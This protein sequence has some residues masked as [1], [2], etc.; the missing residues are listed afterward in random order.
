MKDYGKM[1]LSQ[2]K[3]DLKSRGAKIS[4]RKRE[5]VERLEAYDRNSNFNT[6][7]EEVNKE[8]EMILPSSSNYKDVNKDTEFPVITYNDVRFYL[9]PLGKQLDIESV[10]NLYDQ[11]FLKYFRS[12]KDSDSYFVR[13]ECK[14]EM[15]KNMSYHVDVKIGFNDGIKECQCECAVGLGPTAHCKHVSTVLYACCQF[16]ENQFIQTEETCTQQL[17]TFH[18]SKPYYHTITSCVPISRIL[19][20]AD[21]RH[22]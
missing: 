14:A 3:I 5:L 15:R 12:Y 18:Q 20:M 1:T 9:Q 2:L 21:S 11:R 10:K 13:S 4:G 6:Q 17:Q 8:Y 7:P 19:M 16:L 22:V